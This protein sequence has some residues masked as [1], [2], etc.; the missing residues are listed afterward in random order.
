MTN[1]QPLQPPDYGEID[2][3]SYIHDSPPT[4]E[5]STSQMQ[6]LGCVTPQVSLR[7]VIIPVLN[8]SGNQIN[9]RLACMQT[10]SYL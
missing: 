8:K 1:T 5:D 3:N 4:Y 10:N 9:Q 2:N 6:R 7:Y